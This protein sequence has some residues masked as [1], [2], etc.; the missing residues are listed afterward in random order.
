MH[1][2]QSRRAY[3][4]KHT[5]RKHRLY[6]SV[7][8]C[9]YLLVCIP[10]LMRARGLIHSRLMHAPVNKRFVLFSDTRKPEQKK[11]RWQ[12]HIDEP[13]CIR[14]CAHKIWKWELCLHNTVWAENNRACKN[15]RYYSIILSH[16]TAT[17]EDPKCSSTNLKNGVIKSFVEWS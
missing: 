10:C 8:C 7:L 11:R 13:G 4:Y 2:I 15:A 9:S 6:C 16:V 17:C 14:L 1:L 5:S 3:C 12:I